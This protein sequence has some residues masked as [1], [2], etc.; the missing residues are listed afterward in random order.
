MDRSGADTVVRCVVRF[1]DGK[2][3]CGKQWSVSKTGFILGRG[4]GN[5]RR[6]ARGG[7]KKEVSNGVGCTGSVRSAAAYMVVGL[8]I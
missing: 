1:A 7:R 8:A 3:V 2:S 6:G 4:D 5:M